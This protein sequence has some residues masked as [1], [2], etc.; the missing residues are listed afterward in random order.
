MINKTKNKIL[1]FVTLLVSSLNADSAF[2]NLIKFKQMK[3]DHKT[4]WLDQ[5]KKMHDKKIDMLKQLSKD[6]S[7]FCTDNIKDMK[8]IGNSDEAKEKFAQD[9]LNK[10][11]DL[12]KKH[13]EQFKKLY[14]TKN[15]EAQ[16]IQAKHD[17]EFNKFQAKL[18]TN[19]NK[20]KDS[21]WF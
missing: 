10:A 13:V 2:D 6:W 14:M 15:Q 8:S 20:D 4:Q 9:K 19:T 17:D 3:S 12:H 18:S 11:V 16:D 21:S 1:F 5:K 7:N